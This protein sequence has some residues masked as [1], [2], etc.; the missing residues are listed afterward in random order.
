MAG[1]IIRRDHGDG[2]IDARGPD[3][4]RLRWRVDG[5]RF[6]KSFHGSIRDARKEL[7]RLIKSAD[8]GAHVAPDRMTLA[9]WVDRWIAL[10]R[11]GDTDQPR[12]GLVNARTL[13]RYEEL[14]RLHVSP[15]LGARPLQRISATEIDTLYIRL[16][17]RLATRTVHH[18]HTALG[19]CLNAAVRKGLLVVSP[20]SKADAPVPGESEAGQVL[21][22]DQLTALLIDFRGSVLYPIVAVAAFT[23]ARRN[24]I[25]ALR[26]ADFD[27]ARSTLTIA[28]SLEE[29]KA[30]GRRFKEP[31]T[32]RG[33]RTIAI[34]DGLAGLLSAEREKYLRLTAGVTDGAAVDLSLV[35]LPEGALMFPS[36]AAVETDLTQPRDARSLTKEFIRQARKL[37][38][39]RLRFHDLRGTHET[40][41]L[42]AGV[43][44]HVVAARCG[45]DPAILLR[46]YARRTK[47]ADASAAAIIGTLSERVLGGS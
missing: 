3:R 16:G 37:G 7:R 6:T 5:K 19:A 9:T 46:T 15:T 31:K 42:D 17:E 30:H 41:L 45:H 23:G 18:V 14:L 38:F 22:R 1:R 34:D 2:G 20:A 8:D 11:R 33:R 29:T 44:V 4:W 39:P 24:E 28:R 26:W 36:P 12:R 40:L 25:L 13:E 10:L 35:K 32:R 21:D 43:P 27:P 47:K